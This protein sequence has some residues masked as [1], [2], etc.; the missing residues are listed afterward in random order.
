MSDDGPIRIREIFHAALRVE[1]SQRSAALRDLCGGDEQL[2]TEVRLLLDAN[3]RLQSLTADQHA[4]YVPQK[5]SRYR[6]LQ[7]IGA[8]GMGDVYLAEDESLRRRVAV[9]VLPAEVSTDADRTAR[10]RREARAV[11]MLSHPN[12]VTIH[13]YGIDDG[14]H[15]FVTEYVAGST[16]RDVMRKGCSRDEAIRICASV[17]RAL[18]AAHALSIVHRDI[19]PENVLITSEGVVKVVDFGV[20]KLL[21]AAPSSP[22]DREA[23]PTRLGMVVGT[24]AYMAPE[25]VRG[26]DIDARADIFSLGIVF[27]ELLTG[28]RP[29]AGGT[30]QDTMAAILMSAPQQLPPSIADPDERAT[31]APTFDRRSPAG[32]PHHVHAGQGKDCAAGSSGGRP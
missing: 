15:F 11:A 9:K 3:E 22:Q 13:D 32:G 31:A 23:T 25:Q 8:G 4:A 6:I 14:R 24:A 27:Y 17:A 18:A 1:P 19:K 10:F 28:L 5:L 30:I 26:E 29:F 12:V 7:K 21:A 2:C 20:A 16:L